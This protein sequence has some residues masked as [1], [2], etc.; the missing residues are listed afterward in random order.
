VGLAA[1]G[2]RQLGENVEKIEDQAE[3]AQVRGQAFRVQV[4]AVAAGLIMTLLTLMLP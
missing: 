2:S 3:L 1:R 4:K